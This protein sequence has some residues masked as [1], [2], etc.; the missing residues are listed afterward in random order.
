MLPNFREEFSMPEALDPV[1]TISLLDPVAGYAVQS[2][3]F[4]EASVIRIGRS[5]TNDVVLSDTSVSRMHGELTRTNAGWSVTALG[6]NGIVVGGHAITGATALTHEAVL[7]LAANGPYLEFRFGR[8]RNTLAERLDE[9]RR[10]SEARENEEE[11]QRADRTDA[12]ELD[13]RVRPE[14]RKPGL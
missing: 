14:P 8:R 13:F 7:R 4:E 11:R 5:R 12:T 10:W 9:E 6:R 2:W 3:E 1:I